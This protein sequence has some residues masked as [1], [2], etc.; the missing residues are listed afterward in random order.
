MERWSG[1]EEELRRLSWSS[2]PPKEKNFSFLFKRKKLFI[3]EGKKPSQTPNVS[4]YA[5]YGAPP[6]CYANGPSDSLTSLAA[7]F[8][9]ERKNQRTFDGDTPFGGASLYGLLSR[10]G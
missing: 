1:G 6:I 9:L 3:S 5:P 7:P 2:S 4:R 10:E 8:F